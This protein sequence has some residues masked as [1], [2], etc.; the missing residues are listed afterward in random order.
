MPDSTYF[1]T[2]GKSPKALLSTGHMQSIQSTSR[3]V[4]GAVILEDKGVADSNS[5][6]RESARL[7]W[8]YVSVVWLYAWWINCIV[9]TSRHDGH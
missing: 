5:Q 9:L 3:T 2:E 6:D 4:L 8:M 1:C 7:S